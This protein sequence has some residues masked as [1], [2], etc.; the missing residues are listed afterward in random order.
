MGKFFK[1]IGNFFKK[2]FLG[3]KAFVLKVFNKIKT[4]KITALVMMQLKDKWGVSF[5]TNKKLT[6]L[7]LSGRLIVFVVITVICYFIM[8]FST[9]TLHIFFGDRIPLTAM[10]P[11]IF[12]LTMFEIVSILI[13]MTRS[14]FFAKDNVV[15]ITYPVKPDY[16]FLSKVIVYYV[17]ALK[18]SLMLFFPV[19]ISFGIIYKYSVPFYLWA[20]FIDLFY[21]ALI[22]LLCGL[23]SVPTYYI[24][25]FLD[26]FKIAKVIFA[27]AFTGGL[28]Y[29]TIFVYNIIPSNI[30]L[31]REYDKFTRGLNAFLTTFSSNFKLT[32]AITHVFLGVRDGYLMKIFSN[33]T[34]IGLLSAIGGIAVLVVLNAL[35]AKPFYLK[36]I[37]TSNRSSNKP[38]RERKNHRISGGF[39]VLKYETLRIVRDEKRLVS[40]LICVVVMPLIILIANKFYGAFNSSGTGAYMMFMFNFLFIVLVVVSHNTSSSYIYSKDG[41]S[42]SVN[43]TMPINPVL[44]LSLRLTYNIFTSLFIIIPSS[45][46]F[47]NN[48][49]IADKYSLPLFII[50]LFVIAVF[51]NF[52]SASYDYSNSSNKDKADIGSEIVSTHELI[53][54]AFGI[55]TALVSVLMLLLFMT[56]ASLHPLE[57]L[58]ILSLV[59]CTV[60]IL[61]FFR[62]VKA[63]YQEN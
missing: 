10:I 29:L 52:I 18:K 31:I 22:T 39:S 16:L 28:I 25:R 9:S 23:L 56:S 38:A 54:V 8:S 15:L 53:S 47:F 49:K 41:P 45:I 40:T 43:K 59:A 55:L 33:Y 37:A 44:S 13:G 21:V 2:C 20:L 58:L 6:L 36:M 12:L 1:K 62:K 4:H 14:L 24:L 26:R 50:T 60:A 11:I 5:K 51:H 3:T 27:L 48:S 7:K 46:I 57:R 35:L 42:W 17:D 34:W 32:T 61:S 63:T 30:N 19:I